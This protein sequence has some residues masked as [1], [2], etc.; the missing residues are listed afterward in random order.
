VLE[1]LMQQDASISDLAAQFQMTLTGMKK[2][3][4]ALEAAG[5]VS[6]IKLGR[7]R[8]CTL[9]QGR[10]SAEMDWMERYRRMWAARFDALDTVVQDLKRKE[11]KDDRNQ[12]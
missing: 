5:L 11:R 7:V 3:V 10:L 9:G 4:A 1:R 8:Q 12:G 6:T 2:H